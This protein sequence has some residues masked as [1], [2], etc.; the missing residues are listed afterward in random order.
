LPANGWEDETIELLLSQL[1]M[2]D[3][4]NFVSLIN[5]FSDVVCIQISNVGVGEREGRVYSALVKTRNYSLSHGIGRSGELSA[6]QP[7]AAGS[8]LI[9]KLTHYLVLDALK[10]SGLSL[11]LT[12]ITHG[13]LQQDFRVLTLV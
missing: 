3:S 5:V 4:N 1:S 8:S 12:S 9:L 10:L 11:L 7:K 13:V 2:M 6:E